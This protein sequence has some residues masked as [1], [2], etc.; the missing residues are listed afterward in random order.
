V[1]AAPRHRRRRLRLATVYSHQDDRGRQIVG[2]AAPTPPPLPALLAEV[3]R[4]AAARLAPLLADAGH[5]DIGP[6]YWRVLESIDGADGMRVTDLARRAGTSKQAVCQVVDGLE[7]LGYVTRQPDPEDGRARIVTLTPRGRDGCL[8]GRRLLAE[9]ERGWADGLGDD[10]LAR[11]RDA[12]EEISRYES[13]RAPSGR[14]S[15]GRGR[16]R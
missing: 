12:A 10:L 11:L 1:A 7:E 15:R 9:I 4:A 14:A 5:P 13:G 6:A 3:S 16:A 2:D 8:T